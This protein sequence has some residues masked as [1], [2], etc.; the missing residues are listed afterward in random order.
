MSKISSLKKH[1]GTFCL[2][3][4]IGCMLSLTSCVRSSYCPAY[5]GHANSTISMA[6][7]SKGKKNFEKTNRRRQSSGRERRRAKRRLFKSGR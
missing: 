6:R 7:F 5:A 1:T 3:V 4:A 2:T